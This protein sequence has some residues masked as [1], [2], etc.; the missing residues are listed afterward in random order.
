MIL[1]LVSLLVLVPVGLGVW[2]LIR[3]IS[4]TGSL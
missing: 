1:I 2:E 3:D 4:R